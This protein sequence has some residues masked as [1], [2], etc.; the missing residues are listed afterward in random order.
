MISPVVEHLLRSL[1]FSAHLIQGFNVARSVHRNSLH[2]A[3]VVRHVETQGDAFLLDLGSTLPILK[4][5]DITRLLHNVQ[6]TASGTAP[7]D[8]PSIVTPVF[9]DPLCCF[10]LIRAQ[11][12]AAVYDETKPQSYDASKLTSSNAS[13]QLFVSNETTSATKLENAPR[14]VSSHLDL[15]QIQLGLREDEMDALVLSLV[16]DDHISITLEA[17]QN[18]PDGVWV[19]FF[20]FPQPLSESVDREA[21]FNAMVHDPNAQ[22][23]KAMSQVF[24]SGIAIVGFGQKSGQFMMMS[25]DKCL[26]YV[27]SEV[28]T[29]RANKAGAP[30]ISTQI[31]L[32]RS[33]RQILDV[34]AQEFPNV[35]DYFYEVSAAWPEVRNA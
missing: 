29:S 25:K 1:G 2:L 31:E 22:F 11:H 34:V 21:L 8:Y 7:L 19:P 4:P 16:K 20:M 35:F 3:V 10:Q 30:E 15:S 26:R 13:E 12:L 6:A 14:K 17:L 5:I 9:S 18:E 23:R 33:K 27:G 28:M 24:L 32:M